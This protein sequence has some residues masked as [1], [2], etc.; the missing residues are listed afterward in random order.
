[1][2]DSFPLTP[3]LL[4]RIAIT[5]NTSEIGAIENLAPL[6]RAGPEPLDHIAVVGQAG[7]EEMNRERLRR[8]AGH[9]HGSRHGAVSFAPMTGNGGGTSSPGHPTG[10]RL[11]AA[12][13]LPMQQGAEM[14]T[15]VGRRRGTR[16]RAASA[17]AGKTERPSPTIGTGLDTPPE[18]NLFFVGQDG[19]EIRATSL[20]P[21][22][23]TGG[24]RNLL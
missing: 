12:T 17:T 20:A 19:F 21:A 2:T 11:T 4:H 10:A 5:L 22:W 1:M 13:P 6:V 18:S 15:A 16:K 9:R 14:E 23:E 3:Q 24:R 7:A 8:V